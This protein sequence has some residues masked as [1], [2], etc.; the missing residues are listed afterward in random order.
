MQRVINRF[1]VVASVVGLAA[2]AACARQD[3]SESA[4]GIT[5]PAAL[6]AK[7][8]GGGKGGGGKPGGGG[9]TG[10]SGSLTLAMVTDNNSNGLPNWGDRVRFNVSTTA[11]T[12]PYVSLTC[13]QNGVVVYSAQTGYF[14]S[15]PW[16]WTQTMTLSSTAWQGGAAACTARLSYYSGTSAVS[17]GSL[18]FTAYE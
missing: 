16:P 15:Y 4:S 6:D 3:A 2:S 17:L 5:A 18:N 13:S 7:G 9:S 1:I 14:A 8:G 11:T 10:G 12:E